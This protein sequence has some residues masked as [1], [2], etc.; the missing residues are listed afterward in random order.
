[1]FP[2]LKGIFRIFFFVWCLS[3]AIAFAKYYFILDGEYYQ[4]VTVS[5]S[6]L[7]ADPG[8]LLGNTMGGNREG[9]ARYEIKAV[10]DGKTIGTRSGETETN[11]E[12][13]TGNLLLDL[14]EVSDLDTTT[15]YLYVYCSFYSIDYPNR[16]PETYTKTYTVSLYSDEKNLPNLVPTAFDVSGTTIENL[17]FPLQDGTAVYDINKPIIL[18]WT[19][20]NKGKER[21]EAT[22]TTIWGFSYE[23]N[24]TYYSGYSYKTPALEVGSSHNTFD[25]EVNVD[26]SYREKTIM[27]LEADSYEIVE[28]SNE[29]DNYRTLKP[30]WAVKPVILYKPTDDI[31]SPEIVSSEER[32]SEKNLSGNEYSD[33]EVRDGGVVSDLTCQKGITLHIKNGGLARNISLCGEDSLLKPFGSYAKM[34]LYSGARISGKI[35]VEGQLEV[36]GEP[37]IEETATIAWILC[38]GSDQMGENEV[39]EDDRC[40]IYSL[41]KLPS[42]VAYTI[43]IGTNTVI[44]RRGK[45]RLA[46]GA[47]NFASS[48][49]V[50]KEAQIMGE[51]KY[52][53]AKGEYNSINLGGANGVL[54]L[55]VSNGNLYL[56]ITIPD[57]VL[58]KLAHVCAYKDFPFED[59]QIESSGCQIKFYDKRWI[60][61]D[62]YTFFVEEFFKDSDFSGLQALGIKQVYRPN[63]NKPEMAPIGQHIIAF[64]GTNDFK[65]LLSDLN[66]QGVGYEQYTK[67]KELGVDTWFSKYSIWKNYAG[68]IIGHSLGGALSQMM[69]LDFQN[70][71]PCMGVVTFNS[72]GINLIAPNGTYAVN[73]RFV[74]QFIANGDLVSM[75]GRNF[76]VSEKETSFYLYNAK[77]DELGGVGSIGYLKHMH[78]N[79]VFCDKNQW[80]GVSENCLEVEQS[81]IS[82]PQ[83]TYLKKDDFNGLYAG[84]ILYLAKILKTTYQSKKLDQ[85]ALS[86]IEEYKYFTDQALANSLITRSQA[87][88]AR[89]NAFGIIAE[90]IAQY[91]ILWKEIICK[92]GVKGGKMKTMLI[93]FAT[94]GYKIYDYLRQEAVPTQLYLNTSGLTYRS[95]STQDDIVYGVQCKGY[96]HG[97]PF[98]LYN[99]SKHCFYMLDWRYIDS[100][101]WGSSGAGAHV[102]GECVLK[103]TV[104][105][106]N[107]N[108]WLAL[109]LP[110]TN[111]ARINPLTDHTIRIKSGNSNEWHNILCTYVMADRWYAVLNPKDILHVTRRGVEDGELL[112]VELEIEY[113]I[114]NANKAGLAEIGIYENGISS[115]TDF[116]QVDVIDFDSSKAKGGKNDQ[117]IVTLSSTAYPSGVQAALPESSVDGIFSGIIHLPESFLL[118]SGVQVTISYQDAN[119]GSGK[120]QMVSKAVDCMEDVAI[121]S[122]DQNGLDETF[123]PIIVNPKWTR[124]LLSIS[125]NAPSGK[126]LIGE[127]ALNYATPAIVLTDSVDAS[128]PLHLNEPLIL[129]D[130]TLCL[131]ISNAGQVFLYILRDEVREPIHYTINLRPGWNLLSMPSRDISIVQG[132]ETVHPSSQMYFNEKQSCLIQTGDIPAGY[133]YW[134]FSKKGGL[135]TLS[136]LANPA[137]TITLSPGWHL[138]GMPE[139]LHLDENTLSNIKIWQWKDGHYKL[140]DHKDCRL[141]EGYWIHLAE[142][143][144]FYLYLPQAERN[145]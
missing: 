12:N 27:E 77:E 16:A 128:I 60:N 127:E 137:E 126:Y 133:G 9:R 65:D 61:I 11:N 58:E 28:E 110:G 120:K 71:K 116:L 103:A 111:N 143:L 89:V 34:C 112:D 118:K 43:D 2:S 85:T 130:K 31:K 140:I 135:V 37:V 32:I 73:A 35:N 98:F 125:S 117:I 59:N 109:S 40:T 7:W 138:V 76:V 49:K 114:T 70:A 15:S 142:T 82:S 69:S 4:K 29:G 74:H 64:R 1:M 72:P 90:L 134:L 94:K 17:C 115:T 19:I 87:E 129:E 80:S 30:F 8:S 122:I 102:G 131:K 44:K 96:W 91:G 83:F 101:E 22:K 53:S 54:Y 6:F 10:L 121:V 39:S 23:N 57:Y 14:S 104:S 18:S 38:N 41:N 47:A 55:E 66:G 95:H 56:T 51:F 144:S 67:A 78:T 145:N 36:K 24:G 139:I 136:G 97:V 21:A 141:G 46:A 68:Y 75:V 92:V 20:T 124:F 25:D 42:G 86:H 26:L 48:V 106:V 50:M 5:Y 132:S 45:Y 105:S 107:L 88:K 99:A 84:A 100:K 113:A 63:L 93:A 81:D 33:I 119:N 13:I 62:D 123:N 52:D 3:H 79:I 108:H